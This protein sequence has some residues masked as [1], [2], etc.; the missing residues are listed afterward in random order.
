[1]ILEPDEFVLASTIE[2]LAIPLDLCAEMVPFDER[3][4]EIRTHYAGFFD[5]GFGWSD[6]V[7]QRGSAVVC[8]IRNIGTA[9]VI[10]SH[11][12][13]VCL[14]R[15]EYLSSLPQHGYGATK[16]NEKS[17]YQHQTKVTMAKFFSAWES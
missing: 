14:M 3:Q 8:E 12:Q 17:N 2:E 11:G 6:K 16:A 10:L 4:G 13:P 5:P 7:S 15:F 1:L 9:P